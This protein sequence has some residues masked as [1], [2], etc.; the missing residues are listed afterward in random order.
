MDACIDTTGSV[1]SWTYT[2]SVVVVVEWEVGDVD[3]A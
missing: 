2:L 1:I 3:I